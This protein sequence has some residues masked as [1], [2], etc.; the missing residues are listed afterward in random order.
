[1]T[2]VSAFDPRRTLTQSCVHSFVE[3]HFATGQHGRNSSTMSGLRMTRA[4]SHTMQS[5]AW[6]ADLSFSLNHTISPS[7]R[8]FLSY[9]AG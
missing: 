4:F 7:E 6:Q 8:R 2:H 3:I 1:L 9:P 5:L